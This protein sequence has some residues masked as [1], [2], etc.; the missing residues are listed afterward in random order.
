MPDFKNILLIQ[1]G[2]IGDVVLTTPTIRAIKETYPE[3][4]VSILV[5]K[6]FGCLLLADPRLYEVV[7]TGRALG[8]VFRVLQEFIQFTRRLRRARYDLVIDLR[9]GDR[10]AILSFLTKAPTRIGRNVMDKKFWRGLAY[11]EFVS[12]PQPNLL[13]NHPGADQS[14]HVVRE[15]GITTT[16]STPRL[17]VMPADHECALELLARLSLTADSR[18]V[19]INPCSRW[20]YKELE[21]EKWGAVIDQLWKTHQLPAVLV[22]SP[23]DAAVCQEIVA[24]REERAFNLA[25]ETTLGELTAVLRLSSIHIGVD[26]APPHI[27]AAV[28]TPTLT[29]FGPSNWRGWIIPD[30]LHRIVTSDLPCVPCGQK[31]CENTERSRCLYELGVD[32]ILRQT[33][34]LWRKIE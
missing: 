26:S 32:E 3:S 13:S 24:G 29:I 34:E 16:D 28:G 25:G 20:K 23:E 19:S 1:L 11:T 4:R 2:D 21:Y 8:S 10:G 6:P 12:D 18:W 5:R 33:L 31:G 15:I 9:T 17:S 30:D 27:A 14:L 7:E 22:G